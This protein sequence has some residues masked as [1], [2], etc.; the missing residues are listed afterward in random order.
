MLRVRVDIIY[1]VA[2]PQSV[3]IN[4]DTCFPDL[5]WTGME[6]FIIMVRGTELRSVPLTGVAQG[7]QPFHTEP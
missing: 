7:S 2:L 3:R 6:F 5:D 1:D 4:R